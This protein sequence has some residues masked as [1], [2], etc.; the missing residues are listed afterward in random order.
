[1]CSAVAPRDAGVGGFYL[2]QRRT[3]VAGTKAAKN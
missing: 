1:V 2:N 3:I